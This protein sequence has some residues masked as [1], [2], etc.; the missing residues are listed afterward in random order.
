MV[1]G[2][3]ELGPV[4]VHGVGGLGEQ[5]GMAAFGRDPV[6]PGDGRGG[7]GDRDRAEAAGRAGAGQ[8]PVGGVD[9]DVDS[10][11]DPEPGAGHCHHGAGRP[12]GRR[13]PNTL[14][15]DIQFDLA[16]TWLGYAT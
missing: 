7:D 10:F 13:Q 8:R 9:E 3:A 12:G 6:P 2:V 11:Q 4:G 15:M 16:C 14:G 1:A 5:A